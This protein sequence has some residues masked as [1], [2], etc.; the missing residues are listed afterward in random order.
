MMLA[1]IIYRLLLAALLINGV[2]GTIFPLG[3]LSPSFAEER[4]IGQKEAPGIL[5]HGNRISIDVTNAS[6]KGV[7]QE[8][9]VKTGIRVD[10][11]DSVTGVVTIKLSEVTIE[12]AL[13]KLCQSRALIYEYLPDN[14]AYRIIGAVAADGVAGG[15]RKKAAAV[16]GG[17]T[18]MQN[19]S[20]PS[21]DTAGG[22]LQSAVT[23]EAS[24]T[25]TGDPDRPPYKS[26]ELL[27]RFRPEVTE[28]QV[29]DL[30]RSLASTVIRTMPKLRLQQITIREGLTEDEAIRLYK[31]SGLAENSERHALRYPDKTANDPYVDLQ[32]G[33]ANIKAAEAWNITS[34]KPEVIIA[35][36]D[37]GVDYR[38]PDLQGNIWSNTKELK[39]V[40]GVDDDSDGYVDDIR[41][42]DFADHDNDPMD[43][44]G[45]GTHVAGIIAAMGNNG[46]GIA[47]INWQA[48]IMNL[49]VATDNNSD[50]FEEFAIIAAIQYA[51]DHGAKI[52]NC[53][54]GGSGKSDEEE[55][56]F[57][58]MKDKGILAVCAAGNSSQNTDLY[59]NYPASYNFGNIISVAA[60]GSDDQLASFSNYGP[61]SVDLMAPGV[62]IYS[63]VPE[64]SATTASVQ[65]GSGSITYHAL[66]MSYAGQTD[67]NGI[68]GILYPCGQGYTEQFPAGVSG[69]IALIQRG[70]RDGI[71]FYFQQ[72]VQN[73]Q[74]AGARG[75]II[76]NNVEES[77]AG[78]TLGSQGDWVPAVSITEAAGEA[79][80]SLG[81]PSVT[82]INKPVLN[83][84]AYKSGTSMAVPHVAGVA[85]LLLAQCPSLDY[86]QI[87]SAILNTADP[88]GSVAGKMVSAGRINALSALASLLVDL[89]GD[90]RI[91]LEDAIL[92]LQM[93]SGMPSP[94]T[95][96][97]AA[98]G[99]D[100]SGDGR[101]GLEEILFILQKTAGAR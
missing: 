85:G 7:L 77:W 46:L 66:G 41:G 37:T 22:N 8:M 57:S 60:S 30:H 44:S 72:K 48:K 32:W 15:D 100:I 19:V 94:V 21:A 83:P 70:N 3:G 9:A 42:W 95:Y 71:A 27:V 96:P 34:G 99:K 12:E 39:G 90:F 29:E 75:V 91:G 67:E 62:D 74:A 40:A 88:I 55:L 98:C 54:F 20:A 65:V 63:T 26:G 11:D 84:Y 89:N 92:A 1:H 23:P 35:I 101:I 25:A 52:V 38:H 31:A 73:A 87:R 2:S 81:N 45:H 79:L 6:L 76:Y 80:V 24:K 47:G 93:L 36:I 17:I 49:K 51:I 97:F 53:S 50:S 69:N 58:A 18:V 43:V 64:G 56:A 10:A 28:Q 33:L 59:P 78:G 16:S 86:T 68:T 4:G 14:K 61:A 5:V 82:L 13:E